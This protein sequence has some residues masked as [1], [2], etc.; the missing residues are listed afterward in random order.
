MAENQFGKVSSVSL[1]AACRDGETALKDV[2]F[3][4][5]F[6]IMQPFRKRDGG[7]QVMLLAASA[8]ILEGDR[9]EFCLKAETGAKLEFLSQSY[10]KIHPMPGGSA[11]RDIF[12]RVASGASLAYCPQPVIPFRD[13][14]FE[15]R[16]RVELEDRTSSFFLCDILSC[17]RSARGERFAY[18]YYRSLVE[19]YRGGR[20]I[21]RDNARFEPELFDME[22]MGMFGP[23]THLACLFLTAPEAPEAFEKEARKLLDEE[24]E[25][26]G[27]IT[28]TSDGDFA[29]RILGK[30]AQEMERI[31]KAVSRL[32][33]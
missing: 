6:K 16:M 26:E 24:K 22:G 12:L 18:R 2:R 7:I 30:R 19:I 25:A 9:Q 5:P 8:G 21:F 32:A 1:T 31:S 17:G 10:D 29:V 33:R 23:Y 4:A 14:A 20:L 3:T 13:S 28:R 11:G 27:G 15:S